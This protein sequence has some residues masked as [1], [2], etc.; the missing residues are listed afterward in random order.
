VVPRQH[1]ALKTQRFIPANVVSHFKNT[2]IE[3]HLM[4]NKQ[5]LILFL[6]HSDSGV[7]SIY[8]LVKQFDRADFPGNVSKEIAVLIE[9]G[10]I[11]VSKYFDNGTA[12]DYVATEIGIQYIVDNFNG[13]EMLEYIQ[14]MR[15]PNFLYK[16]TQKLIDNKNGLQQPV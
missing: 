3:I 6:I 7:N 9:Q 10:Y 16:L 12:S 15:I 4:T 11:K 13:N 1:S 8:G 5:K 2:T 14:K